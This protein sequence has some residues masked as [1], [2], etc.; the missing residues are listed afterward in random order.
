MT[1]KA[2]YTPDE[3]AALVRSPLVVGAAISLADPG[4]PFE[5]AK[6]STAVLR[7][8]Q[9]PTADQPELVASVKAELTAMAEQRENPLGDFRPQGGNPGQ[10]VL[11][12]LRSVNAILTGKATPEEATAFRAWLAKAAKD[13][14][15][16]AKEG[17]F[18][19]IRAVRV[20]EG[21]Q[22]MLDELGKVLAG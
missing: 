18:M 19:G 17:G 16:A 3:W 11:D 20:S 13:A 10:Q 4:G 14:A 8:V 1:T 21:E 5:I 2:D 15:N 7:T 12:E 6:E 9:E 22:H